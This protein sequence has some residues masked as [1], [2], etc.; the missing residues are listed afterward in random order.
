MLRG[1]VRETRSL[2]LERIRCPAASVVH[3]HPSFP[4]LIRKSSAN[5]ARM[6][7]C[8]VNSLL[9]WTASENCIRCPSC[10]LFGQHP[11]GR[12][13]AT[14]P[15]RRKCERGLRNSYY[16]VLKHPDH[17]KFLRFAVAQNH[18]V[19]H[20]RFNILPFGVSSAPRV[21]TKIMSE[22]VIFIRQE[23]ICIIPQGSVLGP[24]LFSSWPQLD[25]PSADLAFST[26]FMPMTHNYTHPPAV[27]Q[28]ATDCV[29]AVS[30]IMSALYLKLN[31]SKT[32]LLLLPPSTNLPKSDISH[33]V[34]GT[35]IT[36]R[37]Q[38]RC[39]GVMFDSDLSFTSHIQSLARSCRLHLKN[40]SRICPFLTMET[41]KTL[42]V[43]LIHSRLDYCNALLI[44]LPQLDFPLSSLSL[45][46]QPGS[47]IWLVIIQMHPLFASRYTGC[48]FITGYNSKYLFSP[49]KLSTVR[50]SHTSPSFRSIGLADRCALQM[51]FD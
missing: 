10:A 43:A 50:H 12:R 40:I 28:N 15:Y 48:P 51:T 29:S 6:K 14:A 31:L 17:R 44:G 4:P 21:F 32:E 13:F 27:L 46:Q 16:H 45:M 7:C 35:I 38:A 9:F 25:R 26:I 24:L 49:T 8:V 37:K 36:P 20:Y 33:S 18:R 47:S 2:P 11:L 42:T 30:N 34:G 5:H 22:A 3:V 23:G 39:L 1:Q 41:T 19:S